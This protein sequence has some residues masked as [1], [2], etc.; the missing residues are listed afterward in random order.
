MIKFW[1]CI[2]FLDKALL[3]GMPKVGTMRPF[4]INNN[5]VR[6]HNMKDLCLL[7]FMNIILHY[8]IEIFTGDVTCNKLYYNKEG[9]LVEQQEYK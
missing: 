6:V 9:Q 2:S 7:Q 4:Q 5:T 8:P 1:Q 3:A